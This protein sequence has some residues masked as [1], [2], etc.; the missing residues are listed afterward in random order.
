M[1]KSLI[2]LVFNGFYDWNEDQCTRNDKRQNQRA[3]N[4]FAPY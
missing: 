1:A 3:V 4:S 2:F